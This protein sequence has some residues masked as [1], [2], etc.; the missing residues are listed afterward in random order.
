MT[1]SPIL[2]FCLISLFTLPLLLAGCSAPLPDLGVEIE[3]KQRDAVAHA[4]EAE[5]NGNL[6][7]AARE[8]R[9]L[10][11]RS[12][13]PQCEAFLLKAASIYVRGNYGS[14]ARDVIKTLNS[15]KLSQ[16]QLVQRDLLL[17]RISLME[18]KPQQALKQLPV[19]KV[20]TAQTPA[21]SIEVYQV[22]ADAYESN[23]NYV[24]AART[25]IELEPMLADDNAKQENRLRLWQAL[26]QASPAA[27]QTYRTTPPDVLS[28]W[29]ELAYF[30]KTRDQGTSSKN[31]LADWQARYP[32]HPASAAQFNTLFQ[33]GTGNVTSIGK[34]QH[35]ALLLP[36]SG[37][38]APHSAAVR[39]GFLAAFYAGQKADYRP[40]IRVYDTGNDLQTGRAAYRRALDEG[41]DFIVGP[42]S[43]PLLED[44]SSS[45]NFPVPTLALN[46]TQSEAS[47]NNLFQFGLSPEDEAR[48]VAERAWLDGYS[49]ALMLTP[50][51]E[52]GQ[53]L[54]E[55]FSTH[56][57]ELGGEILEAQTYPPNSNDFA[58]PVAALL[59]VDASQARF[60]VLKQLLG[61]DI[62]FEPA[63][64]QD[65]DFIFVAA[66]PRQARQ[67][68]PQL[69]FQYAGALP[70]Y[71]TSHVFGG[72]A[73]PNLDR[74]MDGIMFPDIPWVLNPSADH[75]PNWEQIN[76]LWSDT[77]PA[78]RR[79]YA[80]GIDAYT[81]MTQLD[82]LQRNRE[83]PIQGETGNL[84]LDDKNRVH[85]QL[86]WARFKEGEPRL[87]GDPSGN[88]KSQ[89]HA[90]TH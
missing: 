69:K 86:L 75:D 82:A 47:I 73:N 11:N 2:R 81:L 70:V 36:L 84:F 38:F 61:R 24:E 27:L 77:A 53:R 3:P 64:R 58:D 55:T 1:H 29:L 54:N 25:R 13:S 8:Y 6:V 78:Y 74:D 37:D 17:A 10:G 62:K 22:R 31:F 15:K 28:G 48:Q 88:S 56:W 60:Q 14:E 26:M 21:S 67:I 46:Y 12:A 68:R 57:R 19:T 7:I 51:G 80:L 76:R 20:A 45:N 83:S 87:L 71:T 49:K 42:L 23:G 63:P 39:D 66:F 16:K 4:A 72:E 85:R 90:G 52:W 59:N 33:S 65:A 34:A 40:D 32:G 41:A 5:A 50:E 43:K 35:I 79:L 18:R 89:N 30:A 9:A 44:L